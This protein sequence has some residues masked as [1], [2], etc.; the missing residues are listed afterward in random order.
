MSFVRQA[1]DEVVAARLATEI[2]EREH[3]NDRPHGESNAPAFRLSGRSR[4]P[5]LRSRRHQI[6]WTRASIHTIS[7]AT[8]ERERIAERDRGAAVGSV[9]PESAR[10]SIG[11]RDSGASGRGSMA[12]S[13][14]RASCGGTSGR[15]VRRISDRSCARA[16]RRRSCQARA[17][18]RVRTGQQVVEQHADAVDVA[19]RR[20]A[21]AVEQ[22]RRQIER[23]A[24]EAGCAGAQFAA[25]TEIHQHHPSIV[26]QHDVV[27]FDIA[28]QEAGRVDGRQ[29]RDR[30]RS[31]CRRLPRR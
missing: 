27:R 24:G 15:A 20:S 2:L 26:C 28:V 1:V 6:G 5:H 23:R 8:R 3:G 16:R 19:R 11:T 14:M 22:L 30:A 17:L 7:A 31:R 4:R 25:G 21:R 29:R 12:R 10:Q 13:M 18:D 9:R